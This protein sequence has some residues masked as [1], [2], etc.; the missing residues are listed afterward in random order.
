[1]RLAIA[2]QSVS[3]AI[4]VTPGGLGTT[5]A[6]NVVAFQSFASAETV[7]AYS[8]T[9]M[10]LGAITSLVI[11]IVALLWAFGWTRSRT[12]L[13]RRTQL[14]ADFQRRTASEKRM[15]DGDLG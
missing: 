6:I 1:M 8:L 11:A 13:R 15:S 9:E 5:Q 2:S 10:V 3:S 4:K 12:M 14:M 7:T